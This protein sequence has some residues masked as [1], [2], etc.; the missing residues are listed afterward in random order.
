LLAIDRVYQVHMPITQSRLADEKLAPP[1]TLAFV[2][3]TTVGMISVLAIGNAK[4][5]QIIGIRKAALLGS[6]LLGLGQ[7]ISGFTSH[8]VAGLFVTAGFV[9]GV[10]TSLCFM[11]SF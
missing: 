6:T 11:A 7:F 5:L 8:N 2:G 10:G 9:M 1:S 3:S 4:L